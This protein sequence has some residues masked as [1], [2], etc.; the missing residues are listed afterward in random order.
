MANPY[1]SR[2]A[3]IRFYFTGGNITADQAVVGPTGDFLSTVTLQATFTASS[4]AIADI[5]SGD[6]VE[7]AVGYA[8]SAG[9]AATGYALFSG[10]IHRLPSNDDLRF[11]L[12]ADEAGLEEVAAWWPSGQVPVTSEVHYVCVFARKSLPLDRSKMTTRFTMAASGMT[13]GQLPIRGRAGTTFT[14]TSND[15]SVLSANERLSLR[16]RSTLTIGTGELE[17]PMVSLPLEPAAT[18]FTV[19]GGSLSSSPALIP[20]VLSRFST[21]A[22]ARLNLAPNMRVTGRTALSISSARLELEENL[23]VP[24]LTVFASRGRAIVSGGGL[25]LRD[26]AGD[27]LSVWHMR[28][29]PNLQDDDKDRVMRDIN[30]AIQ[31]IYSRARHLNYFNRETLTVQLATGASSAALSSR[32]QTFLG[33]VRLSTGEPLFPVGSLSEIQQYPV[34]YR[35]ALELENAPPE[36]YFID[37]STAGGAESMTLHVSPAPDADISI[38]IQVATDAP[39]FDWP[40]AESAAPIALPNDYIETLLLP[41]ARYSATTYRRFQNPDMLPNIKAARDKAMETLGI[42]DPAPTQAAKPQTKEATGTV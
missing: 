3:A 33:E 17:T 35:G 16:G 26:I 42:V 34:L 13:S 14:A 7:I 31:L 19:G 41:I 32:I 11:L 36:A 21:R 29:T 8:A 23:I 27:V 4:G 37:V 25:T 6:Y 18:V 1:T 12:T 9:S 38:A 39:R 28:L 30:S 24:E 10:F 20:G 15:L 22:T 40:D 5:T 2:P